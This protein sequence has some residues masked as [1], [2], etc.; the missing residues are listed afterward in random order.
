LGG[1]FATHLERMRRYNYFAQAGVMVGT[2]PRGRIS[3]DRKGRTKIEL[4]FNRDDLTQLKQGLKT[5]AKIFFAAGAFSVLPATY[6]FLE[7][8]H[9]ADLQ[10]LDEQVQRP[11]DL[12]LGSAHPQ[13]GNVMHED[14]AKGVV[15]TSFR[16]HGFDN[17]YVVDAS[18]F[19]SN[20]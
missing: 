6:R 3:I 18:V 13:G 1:W 19:P 4:S 7:L 11:D 17:L 20:I 14:P 16:V 12:L 2:D 15:D 9:P 8:T 5:L 10:T